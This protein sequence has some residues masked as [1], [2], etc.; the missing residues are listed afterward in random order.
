ML[1]LQL[2]RR[3]TQEPVELDVAAVNHVPVG[4]LRRHCAKHVLWPQH[5][6][7]HWSHS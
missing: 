7:L 5:R 1:L 3:Q 2:P 4:R 6:R